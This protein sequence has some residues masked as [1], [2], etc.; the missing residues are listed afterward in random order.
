[1]VRSILL[2]NL[3]GFLLAVG[4]GALAMLLLYFIWLGHNWPRWVLAPLFICSGFANVI[5]GIVQGN[6]LLF[7]VGLGSLTIFAYLMLAPSVYAFARRQRE[8]I[9]PVESLVV[10]GVL[11]LVVASV[12]CGLYG[13][14]VY[15]SDLQAQATFFAAKAFN[16]I[17]I[18]HDAE[19]LRA[20]LKDEVR[21]MSPS[22][23]LASL[24]ASLGPPQ[25]VG[26]FRGVFTTR[27]KQRRL[28]LTGL[29]QIP[30]LFH[31]TEPIWI[32][33]QVSRI[34]DGWQIDRVGWEFQPGKFQ[35]AP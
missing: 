34:G 3:T 32:N 18:E 27:L 21:T 1:M 12:G 16:K 24:D 14:Y 20:N 31:E 13:F 11:L 15:D 9:R 7:L 17:F 22:V 5:W 30:A 8:T 26:S 4:F 28:F 2:G 19:F 29:F 25:W 33:L 35:P 10:G 23:F 6:G